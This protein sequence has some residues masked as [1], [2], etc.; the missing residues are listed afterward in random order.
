MPRCILRNSKT[1]TCLSARGTAYNLHRED[2][3]SRHE[4]GTRFICAL[5][6]DSL[7][8]SSG[9][10]RQ[11]TCG[12]VDRACA[13]PASRQKLLDSC[14]CIRKSCH[15]AAS[16]NRGPF[17]RLK[18]G[19]LWSISSLF[20]PSTVAS[21]LVCR[22]WS[23]DG[24]NIFPSLERRRYTSSPRRWLAASTD[25]TYTSSTGSFQPRSSSCYYVRLACISSMSILKARAR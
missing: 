13:M 17:R 1:V 14:L 24:R 2:C 7:D 22:C 5:T 6:P 15:N 23:G 8:L 20:T 25:W 9:L 3:S 19:P 11:H 4:I 16:E 18:A 12:W 21:A 10:R